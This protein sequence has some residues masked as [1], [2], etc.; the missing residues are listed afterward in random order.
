[1][2][3]FFKYLFINVCAF[4]YYF[5]NLFLSLI[6]EIRLVHVSLKR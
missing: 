6:R 5:F 4:V 3:F 2:I 1:M